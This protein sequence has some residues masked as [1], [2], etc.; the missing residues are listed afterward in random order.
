MKSLTVA[1]I[2]LSGVFAFNAQGQTSA[3]QKIQ[4]NIPFAF[5]VGDKTLPAGLYTLA[6]VNPTSD[7]KALQ[8]RRVD[9]SASAIIQ[10]THGR[11]SIADGA[12]LVFRRYG[13]HYFFA[14]LETAG[15]ATTL[16]VAR[17]RV[18]RSTQQTFKQLKRP[19]ENTVVAAF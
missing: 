18:E 4:A 5:N 6:V 1:I 9:G 16:T 14:Q 17:S 12:K 3:S 13:H 2:I 7:R 15:D 10:T 19:T 11:G 8:I